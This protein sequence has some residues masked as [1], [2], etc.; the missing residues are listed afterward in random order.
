MDEA[1]QKWGVSVEDRLAKLTQTQKR[2][3]KLKEL[4]PEG[5]AIVEKTKGEASAKERALVAGLANDLGEKALQ[6]ALLRLAG[7]T[8]ALLRRVEDLESRPATM[9]YEGVWR[10][11]SQYSKGSA[12]THDG[13]IFIATI[14]SK[15]LK[16]GEGTGWT[17]ACKRGRDAKPDMAAVRDMVKEEIWEQGRGSVRKRDAQAETR[18]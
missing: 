4:T 12:V 11:D 1:W 18:Q 6:S 16:P 3:F 8:C 10:A 7:F 14:Q 17:L 2:M 13:S 15:G 5:E 9:S